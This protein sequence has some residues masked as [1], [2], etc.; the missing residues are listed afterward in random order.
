MAQGRHPAFE[1][2][3]GAMDLHSRLLTLYEYNRDMLA[4]SAPGGKWDSPEAYA[5]CRF[6]HSLL[7]EVCRD[8]QALCGT[9][10]RL[11]TGSHAHRKDNEV[12]THESDPTGV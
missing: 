4:A 1:A 9:L 3:D 8:G 12:G 11:A 7:E 6:I 5:Y 2:L 10:D